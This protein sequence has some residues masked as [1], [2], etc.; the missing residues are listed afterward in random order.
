SDHISAHRQ[1]KTEGLWILRSRVPRLISTSLLFQPQPLLFS[2][3][4]RFHLE[5]H[6]L[7]QL[8]TVL[9]GF[10]VNVA[11][12]LFTVRPASENGQ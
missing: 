3:D 7:R 10:G 1:R 2:G 11:G 12:L 9:F 4:L 8:L 6:L 5:D